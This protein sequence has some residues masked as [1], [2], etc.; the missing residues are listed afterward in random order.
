MKDAERAQDIDH[1]IEVLKE[2]AND[3]AS[4]LARIEIATQNF[5]RIKAED[6]TGPELREANDQH[7]ELS[8]LKLK[9][10]NSL[11]NALG[12]VR[13]TIERERGRG[14]GW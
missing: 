6:S 2:A 8:K 9:L 5:Q 12:A 7:K 1:T 3:L 14:F 10:Q 13:G 4:A 11:D